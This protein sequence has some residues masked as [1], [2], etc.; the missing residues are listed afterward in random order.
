MR[1]D[2]VLRVRSLRVVDVET[3]V[4]RS[5][6]VVDVVL[7]VLSLR[8]VD[9]ETGRSWVVVDVVLRVRSLRVVDVETGVERSRRVVVVCRSLLVEDPVGIFCRTVVL[10]MVPELSCLVV[11]VVLCLLPHVEESVYL[12]SV[13]TPDFCC[14]VLLDDV[15]VRLGISLSYWPRLTGTVYSC[16]VLCP[17]VEVYI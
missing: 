7:R 10:V 4:E 5:W 17:C 6:V 9:V 13:V 14:D 12:L 1:V 2:V 16:V 8:V 15:E 3:G 11:L